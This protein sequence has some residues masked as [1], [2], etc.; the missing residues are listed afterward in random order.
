MYHYTE[1]NLV[2]LAMAGKKT[3]TKDVLPKTSVDFVLYSS[4]DTQ[5][6]PTELK[7]ALDFIESKLL[8]KPGITGKRVFIGE[9]GFPASAH[10]PEEQERLSRQ[11]MRVAVT[12]GCPFALYWELYNNE[13]EE[14]GTQRGFWLI[15]DKG[16]KQP[17][18]HT[19]QRFYQRA[20]QFMA[21]SRIKNGYDPTA[22]D[23]ARLAATLLSHPIPAK[24]TPD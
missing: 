14:N 16:V 12:W 3:V 11:V 8:P 5:K 17:V 18:Y 1:V 21:E 23:F 15:Y 20:R 4:Y 6:S 19:H 22:E 2:K 24:V 7:A 13:V 9:Y 10:S